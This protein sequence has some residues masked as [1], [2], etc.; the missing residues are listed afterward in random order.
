MRRRDR[1]LTDGIRIAN[2]EVEAIMK[3]LK[4]DMII[5]LFQSE[6]A[7]SAAASSLIGRWTVPPSQ[8]DMTEAKK[9]YKG[10]IQRREEYCK[11]VASSAP[12]LPANNN[13]NQELGGDMMNVDDIAVEGKK[14][15]EKRGGGI[16]GNEE[17]S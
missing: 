4:Y 16:G 5:E 15:Y 12:L 10:I 8:E 13:E 11:A 9:M 3:P 1:M 14:I 7:L 2:G 6:M 17:D